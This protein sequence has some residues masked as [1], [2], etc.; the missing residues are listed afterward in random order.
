MIIIEDIESSQKESLKIKF[1]ITF[2][3]LGVISSTSKF[4]EAKYYIYIY[5]QCFINCSI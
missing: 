4:C 5:T 1:H 3:K 2:K